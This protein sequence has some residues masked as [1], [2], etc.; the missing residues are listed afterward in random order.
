MIH[1]H[2]P[3]KVIQ[4]A[5]HYDSDS[6]IYVLY[7]LCNDGSMWINYDLLGGELAWKKIPAIPEPDEGENG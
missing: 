5:T 7:A 4:I 1:K 2:E 3:R 6:A